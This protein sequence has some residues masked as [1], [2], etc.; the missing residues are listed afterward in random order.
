MI[1]CFPAQAGSGR[2]YM[3]QPS[4]IAGRQFAYARL[5]QHMAEECWDENLA[6]RLRL[7]AQ[8]CVDAA[9][10]ATDE[11]IKAVG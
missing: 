9:N 5:Y 8:E 7:L 10:S 1:G 2:I 4:N 3:S 6:A 11:N